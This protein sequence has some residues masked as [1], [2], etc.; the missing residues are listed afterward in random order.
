[1][2]KHRHTEEAALL[3]RAI[4]MAA[5][6][7]GG[8]TDKA[9]EPYILHPLRVML[10][11]STLHERLAAV[12]H[13]V[14]EDTDMHPMALVTNQIPDEVF[15]ALRALTHNDGE[16]Y[17]EY[18]ARAKANPIARAVKRADVWDNY[19]NP[20]R[21]KSLRPELRERYEKAWAMLEEP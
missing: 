20:A 11:C 21:A 16:P 1:M 14:F 4:A 6:A 18:V 9:G 12:L 7:H 17:F 2:G 10:A 13:D 15:E 3:G 8:Q 19:L 5:T